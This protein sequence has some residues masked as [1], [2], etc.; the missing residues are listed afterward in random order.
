MS[1]ENVHN[2]RKIDRQLSFVFYRTTNRM[3]RMHKPFL[4]PLGLT[5]PQYLVMIE[6]MDRTPRS[7]GDLGSQVGMDTGTITPLL[8]RLEQANLIT[9]RRD[10]KD[11]RRV[12]IDLT[13]AGTALRDPIA[14]IP[15]QMKTACGISD[16][17]AAE[18]Y[19]MLE[20]MELGLANTS[21]ECLLPDVK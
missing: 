21:S 18:L 14:A 7:V 5:F 17:R 16:A 2:R 20:E 11:E 4:Q 19:R 10:K 15:E 1:S 12:M 3:I 6:L 8:K 9:R 13:L